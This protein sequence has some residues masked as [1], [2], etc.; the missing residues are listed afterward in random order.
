MDLCISCN[1]DFYYFPKENETINTFKN[2][3]NNEDGYYLD[4]NNKVFKPCYSTCKKCT[5]YGN[6]S[7]YIEY[8]DVKVSSSDGSK[9]MAERNIC[10]HILSIKHLILKFLFPTIK[11]DSSL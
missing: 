7:K 3:Y 5:E 4:D 1:E 9:F 11:F 6:D 8:V 10:S 2:C